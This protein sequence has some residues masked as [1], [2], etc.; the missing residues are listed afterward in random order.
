LFTVLIIVISVAGMFR[1]QSEGFIVDDLPQ[2]D[3]LYTDL[4]FFEKN[5]K[6]VMPLEIVIDTKRKKGL[7]ANMLKTLDSVD[8][9]SKYISAQPE[10][11]RPL[12]LL[13]G[14]KFIRQSYYGGDSSAYD[15][16]NPADL[17]FLESSSC[18]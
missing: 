3:R 11:A 13:E 2:K 12:S 16:P 15:V 8:V 17:V 5:F 1:L 10:M 18:G 14:L 6:G 4:K 9:L 7:R